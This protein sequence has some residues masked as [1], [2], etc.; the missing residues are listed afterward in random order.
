MYDNYYYYYLDKAIHV[1]CSYTM[2][3]CKLTE[4]DPRASPSLTQGW[5]ACVIHRR[6][7][8]RSWLAE[9]RRSTRVHDPT[10]VVAVTLH[11]LS[12]IDSSEVTV[13]YGCVK[14]ESS[15]FQ[16]YLLRESRQMHKSC[17]GVYLGLVL[18]LGLCSL[19]YLIFTSFLLQIPTS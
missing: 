4:R 11:R 13:C 9:G 18:A 19:F 8:S 12:S 14:C 15:C 2:S 17:V 3:P 1:I 6:A 10:A 5:R 16:C 7:V